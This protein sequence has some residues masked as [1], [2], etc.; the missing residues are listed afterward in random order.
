[1]VK[2]CPRKTNKT[3]SKSG[4]IVKILIMKLIENNILE[5]T[6]S[7]FFEILII[8]KVTVI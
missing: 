5:G 6:S 8:K 2:T 1:V 7:L 3:A 4:L